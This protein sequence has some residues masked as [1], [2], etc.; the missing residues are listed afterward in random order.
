MHHR[1]ELLLG[2]A[3]TFALNVQS[4]SPVDALCQRFFDFFSSFKGSVV[5]K[6][7]PE[8]KLLPED[9]PLSQRLQ[10]NLVQFHNEVTKGGVETCVPRGDYLQLW[11]LGTF[12][13]TET[14]I[15]H[16]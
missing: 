14:N 7:R 1:L 11:Q 8:L 5:F 2:A 4:K 3:W 16:Y 12:G 15:T 9:D 6:Q 13:F 10:A